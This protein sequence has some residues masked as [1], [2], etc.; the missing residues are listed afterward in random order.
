MYKSKGY[1]KLQR[2]SA[3]RKAL[4]RGLTTD[5]IVKGKLETTVAKAKEVRRT[6]EKMI[7][8]GKRQDIHARRQAASYLNKVEA[9]PKQ[10]AVQF[11]FDD[12]APKYQ[13]RKGGYTRI[14][15]TGTRRGDSAEMAIIE[16]V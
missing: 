8:L 12:V 14:I 1:R 11:L 5:L 3:Q 4:L 2:T 7:T 15:K 16:L 9:T 6:T 10:D 13:D